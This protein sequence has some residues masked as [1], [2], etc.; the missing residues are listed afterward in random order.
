MLKNK[1]I[2]GNGGREPEWKI[3]SLKGGKRAQWCRHRDSHTN[4]PRGQGRR[5]APGDH[6]W[7][8]NSTNL[9]IASLEPSTQE[10][11]ASLNFP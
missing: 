11:G 1:C 5:K 10:Y 7:E 4:A 3:N 2:I 8:K 9:L 6:R